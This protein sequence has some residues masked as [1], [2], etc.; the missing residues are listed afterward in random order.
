METTTVIPKANLTSYQRWKLDSLDV[1]GV[2]STKDLQNK[3]MSAANEPKNTTDK[4]IPTSPTEEEITAL[5]QKAEENGHQK[6]YEAGYKSGF[7][8][9]RQQGES[10]IEAELNQIHTIFADLDEKIQTIDQQ[11]AQELLT[12]AIDLT[13]KMISQALVIHPELILP[14]VQ[15]AILQLPSTGQQLRLFLHPKDAVIVRQHMNEQLTQENWEIRED[16]QL[17]Q[18]GCRIEANG[19]EIDANIETRWRRILA[20]I[21][22]KNDWIEK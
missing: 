19:G 3:E 8:E 17:E 6:G 5:F 22:Q 7:Q 1:P 14:I 18:G 21:G 15:E 11:I 16:T 13:K 4:N 2:P 20:A 12:L 9:G 10:V